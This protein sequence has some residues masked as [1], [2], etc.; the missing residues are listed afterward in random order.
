MQKAPPHPLAFVFDVFVG[1]V[2]A[3]SLDEH[4]N[5]PHNLVAPVFASGRTGKRAPRCPVHQVVIAP[6][7]K[8]ADR[9]SCPGGPIPK[10]G[11]NVVFNPTPANERLRARACGVYRTDL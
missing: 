9:W 5:N 2:V 1:I 4:P 7:R 6:H 11:P 10:A 8:L 3:G